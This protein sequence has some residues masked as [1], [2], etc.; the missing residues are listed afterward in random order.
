MSKSIYA[1]V[2]GKVPVTERALYQRINR[3]LKHENQSLRTARSED[4]N[5]GRY[6]IVD[7][8]RNQLVDSHVNIEKLGRKLEALAAWEELEAGT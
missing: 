6:F 3:K 8:Y 4:T 5:L 1:P 7:T 2:T